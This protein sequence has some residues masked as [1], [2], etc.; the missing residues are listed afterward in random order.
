MKKQK[1]LTLSAIG[2]IGFSSVSVRGGMFIPSMT[3]AEMWGGISV[4]TPS[5][6][7]CA[8]LVSCTA[9]TA[10]PDVPYIVTIWFDPGM[11]AATLLE[12]GV[13]AL[14]GDRTIDAADAIKKLEEALKGGSRGGDK[15]SGDT[16]GDDTEATVYTPDMILSQIEVKNIE[17]DKM[18]EN[19]RNAI[20]DYVFETA[21]SDIKGDCSQSDKDCAVARQN[22]WL[23]ASVTLA[24][25]TS[26]K[27]L[28]QTAKKNVKD[29]KTEAEKSEEEKSEG[30]TQTTGGG[31][32]T[33][34]GHF[35]KLESDFNS[36][37]SPMDLYNQMAKIVLDT[38]RQVN[39]AN[40]LLGRDL[41]AQGLRVIVET[42]PVLLDK[43][44]K[45]EE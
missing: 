12:N 1:L 37:T 17:A 22:E 3:L 41:E 2:L 43:T 45:T 28:D 19:T 38:H 4:M 8:D 21:S 24:S 13:T 35:K 23:L 9:A 44:E 18:F 25:A 34:K 11:L 5:L 30:D 39:D 20:K 36:A 6:H 33:L 14:Q 10:L 15:G 40:A 7:L 27:V 42:G 16:S 31:E 26:D 29:G 32:T